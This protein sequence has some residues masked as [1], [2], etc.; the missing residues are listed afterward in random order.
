MRYPYPHR[1]P[2]R[3]VR[4]F[5]LLETIIIVVVI[6]VMAVVAVPSFSGMLA[7]IKVNQVI[8]EIRTTLS[9]TQ[10]TAIRS[11]EPCL[12][13]LMVQLTGEEAPPPNFQSGILNSCNANTGNDSL[14]E[15]IS[16]VT[17]LMPNPDRLSLLTTQPQPITRPST[18]LAGR[19]GQDWLV[20]SSGGSSSSFWEQAAQWACDNW[21]WCPSS[22]SE[23]TS[24]SD[25]IGIVDIAFGNQ[26]SVDYEVQSSLSMPPDSTGKIVAFVSERPQAKQ[27]CIAISKTLGLTRVGKYRGALSPTDITDEGTCTAS[28]W[29]EQ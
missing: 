5:T 22:L 29:T 19:V 20:G 2:S 25:N 28:D 3:Q 16:V 14:A 17:N 6:G 8:T 18:S 1:R 13:S 9:T 27:K 24:P 10:R 21:S 23:P 4:G 7:S 15:G 12:T 26:G 11:G